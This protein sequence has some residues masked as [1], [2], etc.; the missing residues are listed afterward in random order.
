[1][2]QDNSIT[3][4]RMA[5]QAFSYLVSD[6][7]FQLTLTDVYGA[8]FERGAIFISINRDPRSCELSLEFGRVDQLGAF[9]LDELRLVRPDLPLV[10][11]RTIARSDAEVESFIE[12]LARAARPLIDKIVALPP[13]VFEELAR[14]QSDRNTVRLEAARLKGERRR[15]VRATRHAREREDHSHRGSNS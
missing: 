11:S 15:R 6:S 14:L 12:H 5:S 9:L 8:R 13:S 4:G 3:V 1:M 7:G 10:P 2:K